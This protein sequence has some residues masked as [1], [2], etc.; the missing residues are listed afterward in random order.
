M[1][2]FGMDTRHE[3]VG[4]KIKATNRGFIGGRVLTKQHSQCKI[5]TMIERV[6]VIVGGCVMCEVH[7]AQDFL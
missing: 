1:L 6:L 7:T 2:V 4:Q 5:S 3:R